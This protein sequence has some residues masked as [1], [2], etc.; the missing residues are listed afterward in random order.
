MRTHVFV[1]GLVSLDV[2]RVTKDVRVREKAC[3]IRGIGLHHTTGFTDVREADAK[4]D[5]QSDEDSNDGAAKHTA[6]GGRTA[7][8]VNPPP[9]R[10]LHQQYSSHMSDKTP[11]FPAKV[12]I[13]PSTNT[14]TMHSHLQAKC[15]NRS[16]ADTHSPVGIAGV[17]GVVVSPVAVMSV[18]VEAA[19]MV[20]VTA[21]VTARS[22]RH[23]Q[24]LLLLVSKL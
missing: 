24:L 17:H 6:H 13:G 20:V 19:A 8:V 16:S 18:M 2:E 10:Q 3:V 1:R 11:K 4:D 5:G 12:A 14:H 7:P 21:N 23:S 9:A 22:V 15:F